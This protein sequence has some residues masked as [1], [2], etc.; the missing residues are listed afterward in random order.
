MHNILIQKLNS[1]GLSELLIKLISSYLN[2]RKLYVVFEGFK[3]KSFVA[4]S[5]VPQGSNLGP[6]LFNLFINDL[7]ASL[8]T[9]N[10]LFADD[11]KLFYNIS[12]VKDCELLQ[13]DL[14]VIQF[15]C[16]RNSLGLNISKCKVCSFTRKLNPIKFKYKID[17]IFLSRCTTVRDLGVVFDSKFCFVEHIN[18]IC[19]TANKVLGF[20][21]RNCKSFSNIMALKSLY[22]SLVRTKLEYCSAIWYPC[23]QNHC[24]SIERVQRRFLK[25]LY[26]KKHHTYPERGYELKFLLEEFDIQSLEVR[27]NISSIKFLYKLTHNMI[28]CPNLLHQLNFCVPRVHS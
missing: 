25:M 4:T 5:G 11:L 28:D 26:H 15:W 9:Q 17:D 7:V 19:N 2:N 1:F 18:S 21:Y 24:N 22:F 14:N 20:I 8:K 12:D 13:L 16:C 23:Y 3:S 6:L 27:R 10:L